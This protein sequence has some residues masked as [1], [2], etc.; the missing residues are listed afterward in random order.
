[1]YSENVSI[2]S[3][4]WN[5]TSSNLL[6][7][8]VS[9]SLQKLIPLPFKRYRESN[10]YP[11]EHV[12]KHGGFLQEEKLFVCPVFV[13]IDSED[14]YL[15]NMDAYI[16]HPELDR[17][18]AIVGRVLKKQNVL[19]K[20]LGRV[21]R[22]QC[23]IKRGDFMDSAAPFHGARFVDIDESLSTNKEFFQ[24]YGYASK[25]ERAL[26]TQFQINRSQY[27]SI[28]AYSSIG[29]LCV[30]GCGGNYQCFRG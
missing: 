12:H 2:R 27:S 29:L 22:L 6:L 10:F 13:V 25:G 16:F 19:R 24:R 1:L 9:I 14:K 18:K 7:N 15:H 20:G 17:Q 4:G 11:R 8:F 23:P 26:K 3:S 5:N 28:E 21:H 30:S